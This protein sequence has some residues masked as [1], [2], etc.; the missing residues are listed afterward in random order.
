MA[1][2]L[3]DDFDDDVYLVPDDLPDL[4]DFAEDLERP[5]ILLVLSNQVVNTVFK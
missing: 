2:S 4:L 5:F 3:A 1:V